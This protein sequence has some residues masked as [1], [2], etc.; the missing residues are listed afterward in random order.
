MP[1]KPEKLVWPWCMDRFTGSKADRKIVWDKL[2]ERRFPMKKLADKAPNGGMKA[3]EILLVRMLERRD[4]GQVPWVVILSSSVPVLQ[5][6]AILIPVGYSLTTLGSSSVVSTSKLLDLFFQRRPMDQ[7]EADPIGDM[8]YEVQVAG[9]L[10]WE[11]INESVVGGVQQSGRFSA[12]LEYRMRHRLLTVM[13]APYM[14]VKPDTTTRFLSQIEKVMGS[15]VAA[16]LAQGVPMV[17]L[18][19]KTEEPKY[20]QMEV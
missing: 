11:G 18:K 4:K 14:D 7:F 8:L 16:M 3:A 10:S 13:T 15:S 2:V 17:N 9:C 1:W 19:A 6:V 12:I 5:S 20:V